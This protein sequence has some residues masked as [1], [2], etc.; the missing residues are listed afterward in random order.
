MIQEEVTTFWIF[1]SRIPSLLSCNDT[2][3]KAYKFSNDP[4]EKGLGTEKNNSNQFFSCPRLRTPLTRSLH[5]GTYI[6]GVVLVG[7]HSPPINCC[8]ACL[9]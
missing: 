5:A 6:I 2:V 3:Y 8:P 7:I 9:A 1:K 4:I